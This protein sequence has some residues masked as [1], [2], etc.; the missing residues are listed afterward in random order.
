MKDKEKKERLQEIE[1][2]LKE[3]RKQ[4][5]ELVLERRELLCLKTGESNTE[6]FDSIP[7]R[8]HNGLWRL[9][10]RKDVDLLSFL[11]GD[12]SFMKTQTYPFNYKNQ[13]TP[14]NRLLSIRSI[15]QKSAEETINVCKKHGLLTEEGH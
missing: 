4:E 3:I 10:V 1:Q 9:G 12:L 14:L 5:K 6:I 13:K 15:G 7:V 2:L 8:A 11:E